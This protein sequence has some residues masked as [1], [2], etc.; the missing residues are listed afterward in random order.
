MR[1]FRYLRDPLFLLSAG[2]YLLNRVFLKPMFPDSFCSAHLNDLLCIPFCVPI[3]LWLLRISKLRPDNAP[4][5]LHEIAIPLIAWSV[6]FE[7]LLPGQPGF[8]A[9]A[10]YRDIFWYT[11]GALIAS[12]WWHRSE[13]A[14]KA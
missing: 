6:L 2:I 13:K 5:A 7:I 4:P 12:R 8:N 11:L 9:V 3:M 10:D 1:P 14:A